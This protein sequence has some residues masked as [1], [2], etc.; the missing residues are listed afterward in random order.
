M[1]VHQIE[2]FVQVRLAER[3]GWKSVL[4]TA[5]LGTPIHELSHAFFCKVFNH[6]I[7]EMQLFEPDL[8]SGRLGYVK[9]SFRKRNWFEE[10]GNVFIGI[11][12]LIGGTLALMVLLFVFYYDVAI[13]A[14]TQ[15]R[16]R[17][18]DQGVWDATL[19][20]TKNLLSRICQWTNFG[21][22]RFWV[23]A[24]L[25]LCV[26]NHM[27]PSRSDYD[28]ARRGVWMLAIV[29]FVGVFV[30]SFLTGNS[31]SLL[32]GVLEILAPVFSLLMLAVILCVLTAILTFVVT[33]PFKQKYSIQ[34]G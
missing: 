30:L 1:I 12:P 22:L 20:A 13:E 14:A 24:Y 25:V 21:T 19:D 29:V 17:P 10:I 15:F 5:W 28:G 2:R 8:R 31:E 16:D 4:W 3:F 27:A 6:R 9:H 32:P 23:F 7:D 33:L 18:E 26:G 34:V 11:A